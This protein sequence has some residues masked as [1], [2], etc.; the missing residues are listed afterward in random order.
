MQIEINGKRNITL[1]FNAPKKFRLV[2][3]GAEI[4]YI[5]TGKNSFRLS[6]PVDG[7]VELEEIVE[8]LKI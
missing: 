5:R 7:F 4:P 3:D 8:F 6:K 1:D 2:K